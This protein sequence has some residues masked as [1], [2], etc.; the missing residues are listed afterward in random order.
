MI[1]ANASKRGWLDPNFYTGNA[2]VVQL[3][4]EINATNWMLVYHRQNCMQF[5]QS[6]VIPVDVSTSSGSFPQGWPQSKTNIFTPSDPN[7]GLAAHD[8]EMG[9]YEIL[10]CSAVQASCSDWATMTATNTA[11]RTASATAT[12]STTPVSAIPVPTG[13]TYDQVVIGAGAGGIPLADKFS[14]G[15]HSILLIEG[16]TDVWGMGRR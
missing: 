6:G 9:V 12:A 15:V 11:T 4:T 8:N 2:T 5:N 7:A 16:T 3:Y 14:E 13:T 1:I 10:V